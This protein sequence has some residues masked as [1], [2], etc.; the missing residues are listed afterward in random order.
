MTIKFNDVDDLLEF[1]VEYTALGRKGTD[2]LQ[3]LRDGERL[4]SDRLTQDEVQYYIIPFLADCEDRGIIFPELPPA[5][6]S[7]PF[8]YLLE[9]KLDTFTVNVKIQMMAEDEHDAYGVESRV[10][11]ALEAEGINLYTDLQVTRVDS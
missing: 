7:E 8:G 1:A 10:R 3:A 2:Q 5:V 9:P 6:S 11:S 4:P